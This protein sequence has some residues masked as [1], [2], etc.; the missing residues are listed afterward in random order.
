VLAQVP[1]LPATLQA[2]QLPVHALLQHTP[3]TQLPLAHWLAMAHATPLPRRH[4]P[5]PLHT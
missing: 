4:A 3:S 2:W 1:A 5:T